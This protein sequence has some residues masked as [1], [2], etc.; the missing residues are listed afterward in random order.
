V[1][2]DHDC[3][4]CRWSL[5]KLLRL[6][7]R[8]VLIPVALGTAEADRLLADMEPER[9]MS[10]WHLVAPDGRR[11]SAGAAAPP[12]LRLL[13]VTGPLGRLLAHAPTAT[14]RAYRWVADRRSW[15]GGVIPERSKRRADEVIARHAPGSDAGLRRRADEVT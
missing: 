14:D 1:I 11:H 3:G 10:S 6:D 15:F 13:P 12:L 9:R 2:Y 8:H 5:A 4:F 7:R